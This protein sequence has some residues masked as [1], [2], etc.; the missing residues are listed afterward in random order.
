MQ[1]HKRM[2][3][4][5]LGHKRVA[6]SITIN[7][8]DRRRLGHELFSPRLLLSRLLLLGLISAPALSGLLMGAQNTLVD[9][10]TYEM[11]P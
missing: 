9:E 4:A 5:W 8:R 3:T 11:S 2:A 1:E 7:Y 6:G 10:K